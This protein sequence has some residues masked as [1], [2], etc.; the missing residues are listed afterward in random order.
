MARITVEDCLTRENNRF[1]LVQLAA[2]RTKQLL[3]GARMLID[4]SR[5]NKSVV[6]SLREI[7]S[8]KVRFMTSEEQQSAIL[9]AQ[10]R[11]EEAAAQVAA[12][13][14]VATGLASIGADLFVSAAS[15]APS[16]PSSNGDSSEGEESSSTL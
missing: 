14:A 5:G 3:G 13:P 10:R 11:A 9:E 16:A 6:N 1:A 2:K 7:A 8:G 12:A 4:S 15:V